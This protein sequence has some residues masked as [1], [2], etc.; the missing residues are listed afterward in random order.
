MIKKRLVNVSV[1]LILMMIFVN[2]GYSATTK[3][4]L[5]KTKKEIALNNIDLKTFIVSSVVISSDFKNITY[6][7]RIKERERVIF[8]NKID[9]I[10]DGVMIGTP[11]LIGNTGRVIYIAKENGAKIK[12]KKEKD[13][14]FVIVDGR[15]QKK[16]DFITPY[17]IVISPDCNRIVYCATKDKKLFVVEGN[18]EYDS[19]DRIEKDSI[20][21][22]P[23]SKS[24]LFVFR[25]LNKYYVFMNGKISN[26]YNFI[27]SDSVR[28]SFDSKHVVFIARDKDKKSVILDF[29]IIGSY[30]N[31]LSKDPESSSMGMNTRRS[32]MSKKPEKKEKF[33]FSKDGNLLFFALK[34]QKL[35]KV[36]KKI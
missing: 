13:K 34:N 22:S 4:S 11:M 1:F 26:P 7:E 5:I 25:K 18:K 9:K 29:K 36:I 20:L 27:E 12:E 10:Y 6:V 33:Y 21:F 31:I 28:F 23:D 15:E 17:S 2:F 14:W 16:Y 19:G 35:Y 24:L 32:M 30:D 8:N 3:K